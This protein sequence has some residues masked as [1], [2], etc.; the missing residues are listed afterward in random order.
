VQVPDI[1]TV[2]AGALAP[3]APVL[4]DLADAQFNAA[5]T[6]GIDAVSRAAQDLV[7]EWT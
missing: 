1:T 5:S 7:R 4:A 6:V 3:A 2:A